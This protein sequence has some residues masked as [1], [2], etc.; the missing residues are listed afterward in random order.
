MTDVIHELYKLTPKEISFSS[1]QL[2][3]KGVLTIQ[4]YAEASASVNSFQEKLVKSPLFTDVS[5]QYAT[6]RK[7]FNMDVTDFK[8]MAQLK[9]EKKEEK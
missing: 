4:G 5:L 2:D 8:I 6:K 1:L 9:E 7:I 3:E